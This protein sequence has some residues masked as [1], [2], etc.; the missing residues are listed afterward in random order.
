MTHNTV[1]SKAFSQSI[2][3]VVDGKKVESER[4]ES[5]WLYL[6]KVSLTLEVKIL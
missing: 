4:E 2:N 3:E 1:L 5:K 6:Y